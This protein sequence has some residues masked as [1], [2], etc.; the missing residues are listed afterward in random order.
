MRCLSPITIEFPQGS[1]HYIVV[2]CGHCINCYNNKR[3]DWSLRLQFEA[4]ATTYVTT[5]VT[6]TYA[7]ECLPTTSDGKF[8][9]HYPD[10]Q[11]FVRAIRYDLKKYNVTMRYFFCGEY[12][13]KLKRPHYHGILYFNTD[14]KPMSK[15]RFLVDVL[16]KLFRDNWKF[17]IYDIASADDSALHYVTKYC[18]KSFTDD[19]KSPYRER[20]ICST[21]PP[22]GLS[23]LTPERVAYYKSHKDKLYINHN[24]FKYNLPRIFRKKLHPQKLTQHEIELLY[25][26]NAKEQTNILKGLTPIQQKN[27]INNIHSYNDRQLSKVLRT[28]LL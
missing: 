27:Y 13:D 20:M 6:L 18:V 26:Q 10:V 14:N 4:F 22:I 3:N 19:T 15:E 21:K 9:L 16:D 25:L 17:G 1:K 12:G 24:G 8:V 5:F 2:P 11:N 23:W 28:K 7:D